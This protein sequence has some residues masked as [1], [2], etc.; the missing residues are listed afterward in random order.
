MAQRK[1]QPLG[2]SK[3][4]LDA[5]HYNALQVTALQHSKAQSKAKQ[6]KAK[7]AAFW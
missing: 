7:F 5:T 4:E 2:T 6:G 3:A 1:E